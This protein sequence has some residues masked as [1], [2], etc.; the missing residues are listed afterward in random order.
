[1]RRLF[2]AV[3][4][5]GCIMTGIAQAKIT[6]VDI[7]P[8]NATLNGAA[9]ILGTTYSLNY[10]DVTDGLWGYRTNRTDVNGP[11]IWVTDGGQIVGDSES[12]LPLK[13]ELTLPE[14]GVL[15]E[16]YAVI[17]N[18]NGG[19]GQWDV[20]ARIGDAG[21][22]RNF[23]KDSAEMTRALAS[24]FEGSVVIANGGDMTAK[25]RIGYYVTT[26]PNEIVSIYINGLDTWKNGA[27]YD[28]R[29]RFDGVGYEASNAIYELSPVNGQTDVDVTNVALSWVG[30]LDP[31]AVG[32]YVYM[33]TQPAADLPECRRTG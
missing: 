17:M 19:G 26:T 12:T 13:V 8:D 21:D 28:Q 4:V 16:L 24:D 29:T 6:Y 32:H 7:T 14:A 27:S 33:G 2:T 11:G 5:L 23:N 1:M 15:Y 18:N 22:F 9:L 20:S 30:G 25:V 3:C 10:S 31:N